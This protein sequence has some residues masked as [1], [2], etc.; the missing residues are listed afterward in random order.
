VPFVDLSAS[1]LA[2]GVSAVRI[3]YRDAGA[4]PPIV[5]LHGGWGYEI[6]PLDRQ[7]EALTSQ[8]RIVIPDRSGYGGSGSVETLPA[9]FHHRA[10][11]ETRSFVHALGLDRPILW[12]HSDGAIIAL[13]FALAAPDRITGVVAEATH[14]FKRKPASR[15]FFETMMENPT[16]LG[17]G[18]IASLERD[19]GE[20]WRHVL[21]LNARAWLQIA[22]EAASDHE[23]LYGGRLH[24]LPVPLLVVHGARDPRT[25]PGE[26]DALRAA[27]GPLP[28]FA[29]LDAG[30]HSPHSERATADDVTRLVQAFAG[31]LFSNGA[32][33]PPPAR[34]DADTSPRRRLASA[35]RGRG[36]SR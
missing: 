12:G 21:E 27:L 13:L 10:V 14:Y 30:G 1:P 34:A 36:R 20:R 24:E 29:I 18:V 35:R 32:G 33:A 22:D 8:F 16:S 23:D 17:A 3:R 11:A 25:E 7:I 5:F 4:G 2:P 15:A 6:Y 19:H 26:L 31:Q 9:D 28:Q